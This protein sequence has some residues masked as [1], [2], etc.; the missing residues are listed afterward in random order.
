M[1]DET[2]DCLSRNVL[3]IIASYSTPGNLKTEIQK[4]LLETKFI[5]STEHTIVA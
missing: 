5:D 4:K 2:T 3:N 1:A